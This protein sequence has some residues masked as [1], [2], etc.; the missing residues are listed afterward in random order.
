MSSHQLGNC[1][2]MPDS[3][4]DGMELMAE[5]STAIIFSKQKSHFSHYQ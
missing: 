1:V 5:A 2:E 4:Q 3:M